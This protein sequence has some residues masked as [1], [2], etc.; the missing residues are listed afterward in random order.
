MACGNSASERKVEKVKAAAELAAVR[1]GIADV[2]R[3]MLLLLRLPFPSAREVERTGVW[4]MDG[5]AGEA[6]AVA[7]TVPLVMIGRPTL[8]S[9]P[10]G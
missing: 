6:V 4:V 10:S 3:L 5:C 9:H 7:G 1:V 8:R 2:T